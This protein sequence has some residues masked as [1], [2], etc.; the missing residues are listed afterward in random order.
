MPLYV[1]YN[2]HNKSY[3][4]L[5]QL[6]NNVFIHQRHLQYLALK[7]FQSFMSANPEFM[8]FYFNENPIPYD[9]RK[10]TKLLLPPVKS[11]DLGLNSA[12]FRGSILRDSLLS[13]IENSR[14]INEFKAKLKNVRMLTVH[15]V[16]VVETF[17]TFFNFLKFLAILFCTFPK[18]LFIYSK[19][20]IA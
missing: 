4:E 1:I 7:V 3:E 17:L 16:C 18:Y 19:V 11:F 12:Y 20:L 13:S 15:V 8:W 14:T 5:L 10:G 6:N 9:L 2:E